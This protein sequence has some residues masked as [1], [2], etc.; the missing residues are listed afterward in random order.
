MKLFLTTI[1][2]CLTMCCSQAQ[3]SNQMEK[4]FIHTKIGQIA[5]FHNQSEFKNT[6]V[7]FLHGVYFDHHLWDNQLSAISDRPVIAIDMPFHGESKNI[8]KNWNLDDCADMLLEILDSLKIEKVIA[9]GHSWGSMTIIRAANKNPNRFAALGLC[10]MPFKKPSKKEVSAIKF[11]HTAMIFRK[12][13]MKQAGKALMGKE[14]IKNNPSLIDKLITSM[15]KLS[16]KE[17]KYTDKAVRMD[18]EDAT[19]LIAYLSMP[20]LAMIGEEDY[21]GLP[22]I[23]EVTTVKGGH[24]SP[25]EASDEVNKLISKLT[26]LAD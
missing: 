11:Q 14:S 16:N 22:P 2:L 19:H 3:K 23:K 17:I 1:S 21:V 5:I 12:F 24:V 20:V 8:K 4:K 9:V 26:K 7:I 15:S 25:I 6:P 10:N 13:Y 18:A